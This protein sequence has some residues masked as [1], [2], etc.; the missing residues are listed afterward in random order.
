M[1]V[2]K[3]F[4]SLTGRRLSESSRQLLQSVPT[5]SQEN[6]DH[7]QDVESI[8]LETCGGSSLLEGSTTAMM[9]DDDTPTTSNPSWSKQQQQQELVGDPGESTSQKSDSVTAVSSSQEDD[10]TTDQASLVSSSGSSSSNHLLEGDQGVLPAVTQEE[11]SSA[12]TSLPVVKKQVQFATVT[13]HYHSLI[14][15]DHPS[16]SQGPPIALGWERLETQ[17]FPSVTHHFEQQQQQRS[18]STPSPTQKQQLQRLRL[19]HRQRVQSLRHA[20]VSWEDIQTCLDQI[21]VL[22]Q[23]SSMHVL[24]LA[25]LERKQQKR[26]GTKRSRDTHLV[27]SLLTSGDD[28]DNN[29]NHTSKP[30]ETT[31][32]VPVVG[33]TTPTFTDEIEITLHDDTICGMASTAQLAMAVC[34]N[35]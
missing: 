22:Q 14:L 21:Q 7:Q 3:L 30:H 26:H 31:S 15:G 9:E 6:H 20:G 25:L 2:S 34:T 27:S 24:Q 5:T 1:V 4:S 18:S 8:D 29:N 23:A 16:V 12:T 19:S 17:E 11:S 33:A 28:N 32:L 10:E 35:S 13:I